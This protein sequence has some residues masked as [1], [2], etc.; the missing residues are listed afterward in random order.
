MNVSKRIK[1]S[2]AI[3][4]WSGFIYQGKIALYHCIHL[5]VSDNSNA[6]HLKVETLDDFVIYDSGGKALSL[7]QVKARNNRKRSAYEDALKQAS[8]ISSLNVDKTTK[9]W[10]HVS[11]ELDDC[12]SYSSTNTTQN[13]VDFY[14]YRD[15][16]HYLSLEHVNEQLEQVVSDYL[17]KIKLNCTPLLVRY[18]LGLLFSLLDIRVISAHAKIHTE[19]QLKFDAANMTPISLS[20]IEE[21]LKSEVFDEADEKVV[22]N[23]FRRNILDRTDELID[24]HKE[25]NDISCT[26]V[27]ACRNAIATMNLETLKRLYYSKKPNLD[28]ISIKGFNDDSVDSYM[29]IVAMLEE[30]VVLNDLPHYHQPLFGT[31]LPTAIQLKKINEKLSLSDIQSN[32]EALRENSIVQDVLYEYNNLIVDMKHSA[33][34]LSE[35]SKLTGKFI[36]ISDDPLNQGRL[37]KIHNVRFISSDDAQEELNG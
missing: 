17:E 1:N 8:E 3:A 31:Y 15:G 28:A 29:G 25:S 6:D 9:R 33:F 18:K 27:L 2:S 5:L 7:H 20:E 32:V 21:C 24:V 16:S 19:G 26:D 23:R 37:T 12:S 34:P 10:F 14:Q 30:L 35:A 13:Q 22:L 36:D 11:C 4:S